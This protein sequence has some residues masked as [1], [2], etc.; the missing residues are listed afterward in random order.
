[1]VC[2]GLRTEEAIVETVKKV[3]ADFSSFSRML[4]GTVVALV[5]TTA[6]AQVRAGSGIINIPPGTGNWQPS[7]SGWDG[8]L[9]L[10]YWWTDQFGNVLTNAAGIVDGGPF[11]ITL[12]SNDNPVKV[13]IPPVPGIGDIRW[14]SPWYQNNPNVGGFCTTDA[15]STALSQAGGQWVSDIQGLAASQGGELTWQS[16]FVD[17]NLN[18]TLYY[19]VDLTAYYAAGAPLYPDDGSMNFSIVDG[20]C[21]QLP[22]YL[23]GT[24]PVNLDPLD[25]LVTDDPF[26]GDVTSVMTEGLCPEPMSLALLAFGALGLMMRPVRRSSK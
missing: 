20:T 17:V 22:G 23:F 15:D 8:D 26:T 6:A 21:P 16:G 14:K 13:P 2:W 9:T 12:P 5:I 25:G 3:R 11:T 18:A 10:T 24:S 7:Y 1:M 19:D 4:C